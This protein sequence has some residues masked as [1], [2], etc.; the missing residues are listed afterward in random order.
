MHPKTLRLA[1]V[2][3]LL[4]GCGP[5]TPPPSAAPAVPAVRAVIAAAAGGA[6]G[7]AAGAQVT[8]PPGAL[9]KD[10]TLSL[11]KKPPE[12]YASPG[13][14]VIGPVW[15]LQVDGAEHF[16]FSKP[17]KV[18]LPVDPALR[19]SGSAVGMTTIRASLPPAS[20]TNF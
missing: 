4:L 1:L 14:R 3:G 17:V 5:K 13:V 8:V 18:E 6:L 9:P 15:N 2:L 11:E 12:A 20:S 10:A 7:D 19:T 16:R